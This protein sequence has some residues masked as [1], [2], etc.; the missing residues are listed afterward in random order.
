MYIDLCILQC[1]SIDH[2]GS[3]LNQ[4]AQGRGESMQK[5]VRDVVE[6]FTTSLKL[7]SVC[8]NTYNKKLVT[9]K[10]I[11]N[12]GMYH[13]LKSQNA[14]STTFHSESS[15]PQFMEHYRRSF[16]HATVLPKMHLLEDHVL[17]WLKRWRVGSGL[18]GEQGAEQIH[19]H[20]HHLEQ[21]YRGIRDPLQRLKYIMHEH[22]LQT[23]PELHC[24][25]PLAKK[26]RSF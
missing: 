26:R 6:L 11:S 14:N 25:E 13:V 21:V 10:D 17:P 12:L 8:H 16:P 15:I 22:M 23:A 5:T 19:S 4:E 20:I 2:I 24:L 3:N 18:M 7:F 1:V 9:D